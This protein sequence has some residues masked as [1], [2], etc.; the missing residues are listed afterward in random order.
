MHFWYKH[1]PPS[2]ELVVDIFPEDMT[3][4]LEGIRILSCPA[5]PGAR[6]LGNVGNDESTV[7]SYG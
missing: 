2:M 7:I 4:G 3:L 6:L 1:L 5:C